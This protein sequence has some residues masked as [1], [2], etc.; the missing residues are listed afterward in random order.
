MQH[1]M[2]IPLT[3]DSYFDRIFYINLE[4]DTLRNEQMVSQFQKYGITNY[5]R[6]DGIALTELPGKEKYR[7]F[8]KHDPRYQIG[9]LS[10]RASHLKCIGIAKQRNFSSVLILEDDALFLQDPNLLLAHNRQ[11][12]NDW[13]ML[14]FGGLVEPHFRNQIVCTH[15]YC[16]KNTLY[17]DILN[18]ADASGMEIDNFYAKI[19]QHMSY[20]Y[21]HT[22]KYN[23]RVIMPFNQI[24]QNKAL[25]SNI[26]S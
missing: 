25:G 15:A 2:F 19:L 20:N 11:M 26:Q 24:V 8:I 16:V 17:D 21:N 9:Q 3:L 13:D 1:A 23:I 10:C 14:Y 5:E 4:R 12:L 6:V 18:M 7:N 22:G